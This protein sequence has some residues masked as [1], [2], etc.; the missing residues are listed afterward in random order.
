[1]AR[2][3]AAHVG[4]ARAG[5]RRMVA[6][7]LGILAVIATSVAVGLLFSGSAT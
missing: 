6:V 7:S 2:V 1:M 3:I 4:Y 5:D